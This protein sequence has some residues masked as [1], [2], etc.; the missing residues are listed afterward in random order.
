MSKLLSSLLLVLLSLSVGLNVY[1]YFFPRT[2]QVPGKTVYLPG[3]ENPADIYD[4]KDGTQSVTAKM[5]KQYAGPKQNAKELV[6]SV[7]GIPDIEKEKQITELIAAKMK[8]ELS[9]GE[10]DMA[11]NDK[12]KQVKQWQDK[13][14]SITVD[15][16]TNTASVISEVSP[17]I[18]TTEKRDGL[19]SPKESY[20]ILTSENPAV[21][22]Y[23]LESYSFKNPKTKDFVRLNGKIQGFYLNETIT[24]YGGLEL[25]FAPDSRISPNISAGY[26]Y[27]SETGRVYQFFSGGIQF[28]ILKF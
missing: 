8:L 6:S 25:V 13:F 21:K 9:L 19:F 16:S 23:G 7:K 22:F 17:R 1:W 2:E 18:V 27:H 24:P 4:L 26:F 10:K 28:N 20:T 14:N 3:V 15:N 5:E 12:D 11:I